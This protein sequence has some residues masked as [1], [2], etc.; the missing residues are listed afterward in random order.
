MLLYKTTI[1][2]KTFATIRHLNC[3]NCNTSYTDIIGTGNNEQSIAIIDEFFYYTMDDVNDQTKIPE[4]F[5]FPEGGKTITMN[6][7]I[8]KVNEYNLIPKEAKAIT[9]NPGL[10]CGIFS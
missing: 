10:S 9:F 1:I 4:W 3:P 2:R 5:I 6:F 7:M 8:N